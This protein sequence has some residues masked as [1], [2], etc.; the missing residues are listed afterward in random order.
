MAGAKFDYA[1]AQETIN[2][3]TELKSRLNTTLSNAD[4]LIKS[5]VN[6]EEVWDSD[7]SSRFMNDWVKYAEQSFPSYLKT[8]EAQITKIQTAINEYQQAER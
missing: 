7:T 4:D 6:N 3:I 8:F 2:N 1:K 5:N